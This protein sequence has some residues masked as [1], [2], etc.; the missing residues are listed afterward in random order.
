M[1]NEQRVLDLD[2]DQSGV[3][4]D[5]LQQQERIWFG[6]V[7]RLHDAHSGVQTAQSAAVLRIARRRWAEAR[8][9]L[10]R[11]TAYALQGGGLFHRTRD[12]AQDPVDLGADVAHGDDACD[13]NQG[14]DQRVF[15]SGGATLAP[16]E[17]TED[18]QHAN[19][20]LKWV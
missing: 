12:I 20:P 11:Q 1:S 19:A 13:R 7:C 4:L 10:R 5:R 6:W 3:G 15:N 2:A 17:P 14:G 16:G 9:A 8:R 18:G